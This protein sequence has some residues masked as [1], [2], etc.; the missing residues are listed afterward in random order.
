MNDFQDRIKKYSSRAIFLLKNLIS[1]QTVLEEYQPNSDAPFG[2]E[3][4]K[5]L[6]F[7]LNEAKND[8]FIV[9]NVDNYAGHVEFGNGKTKLGILAHLDVVP[10]VKDEWFSDPFTLD[11]RENR[12]YARGALDDKGP[13][14][15]SYI[16]MKML[17]DEGF[18]PSGKV[19]LIAGCDEESGSRC[20]ERYFQKED[21]PEMGFSPDAEFPLIY[22]EKAM[23]SFDVIALKDNVIEEI[24]C[25][26]RYNIVPSMTSVKLNIFLKNEFLEYLKENNY[27]G[28]V[29]ND[30]YITY[31]VSSHAMVPQNGL[32][33]LDIM[34]EFLAKYS[35]SN[36]AKF[37]TKYFSFDPFGKKIGYDCYDD[38]LK[39][40]TSNRAL[41]NGKNT[42]TLGVNCRCPLDSCYE[43]IKERL[44]EVTKEFGYSFKLYP[45]S[46]RHYVSKDSKLVKTLMKAYKSVTNNDAKPF[47]IGGGTYARELDNAVA[48]G[49]LGFG[50]VDVCHISNEYFDIEDFNQAIE[51]YYNAIKELMK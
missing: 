23:V 13:L 5:A 17:K 27:K 25:G 8:G 4:K 35:D 15:A 37:Y 21:K 10:V 28:E 19:R 41:C 14:V 33:A 45:L 32:S 43:V 16:A 24:S 22:G 31:G 30:N 26:K 42:I 40:L 51:I 38:E 9:K 2:I 20:I 6:N 36:F 39:E 34:M 12:F 49:A 7:L 18:I 50:K 44:V 46:P 3:N 47:T 48:F 29:K 1:F 11:I